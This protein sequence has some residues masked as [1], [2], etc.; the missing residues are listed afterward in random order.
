M[1]LVKINPTQWINS[2]IGTIYDIDGA[3]GI[4]CVDLM[5][6]F[7]KDIGYPNPT[8][9]IGGDGYADQLWYR[10]DALGYAPYFEYIT[11]TLKEGD[12][13]LWAKGSP[14]CPYSHIAMFV[15]DDPNDPNR[16]IFLG[17]NQGS[18]HS[19]GVLTSISCTGALGALR[20]KGFT[21]DN[22]SSVSINNRLI[23]ENGVM[24]ITVDSI[25]ARL[26][27]P[28]GN[29][30]RRY[31]M[32]DVVKYQY[33]YVGNGHRYIVWNE[34]SNKIYLAVS[35]SETYG[36]EKWAEPTEVKQDTP[37]PSK[38]STNGLTEEKGKVTFKVDQVRARKN[39]PTGEVVKQFMSG[40]SQNYDYKYVGNGHRYIV[41]K[42]GNDLIYVA[43]TPTEERSTEWADFGEQDSKPTE[44]PKPAEPE[45]KD[46]DVEQPDLEP[47][48]Y[49]PT[50]G[51]LERNGIAM[52][53]KLVDK[54]NYAVKCPYVI[55]KAFPVVHN[56]GT[57]GDPDAAT[58][59][60]SMLNAKNDNTSWHFSVDEKTIVQN[61]PLN[62]NCFAQ[63][64]F[65]TG[66]KSKNGISVEICRDMGSEL[67][68]KSELASCVLI[69]DL[70]YQ[71]GWKASDIKKHQ[72]FDMKDANGNIFH[73]YCPHKTLNFGWDRY[74]QMVQKKY[75]ELIEFLNPK[76][77]EEPKEEPK[78]DE[79]ESDDQKTFFKLWNKL[80]KRVLGEK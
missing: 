75:D 46:N 2:H 30:V 29:I 31:K 12:I 26:N 67:F 54:S 69:A 17:S 39:S 41:Y 11:G 71:N 16:G 25:N 35:G 10:R 9:A 33:K 38:P 18:A 72:D 23:E 77:V 51:W 6:I 21:K 53:Y 24:K 43:V 62:R 27:S 63:G 37:T 4:Q 13:T 22:V 60:Q 50:N 58:L 70:L 61:L 80:L 3:F 8:R 56:A 34:G 32:N 40:Q 66:W 59:T 64:D 73:K 7:L 28:T 55:Q 57:P 19:P 52:T 14:E 79:E 74:I 45:E 47:E 36:V 49:K 5:K 1:A 65:S 76:S 20:Y 42:D 48:L 78:K 44:Q 15:K 68:E